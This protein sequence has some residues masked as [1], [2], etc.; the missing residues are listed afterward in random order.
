MVT[1]NKKGEVLLHG[2]FSGVLFLRV[3]KSQWQWCRAQVE[4]NFPSCPSCRRRPLM[5]QPRNRL[6]AEQ[7]YIALLHEHGINQNILTN[8]GS[9]PDTALIVCP[10]VTC[11]CGYRIYKLRTPNMIHNTPYE[12]HASRTFNPERI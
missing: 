9:D 10:G 5:Y 2:D 4:A 1:I 8:S 7:S 12:F 3:D 6:L 11:S